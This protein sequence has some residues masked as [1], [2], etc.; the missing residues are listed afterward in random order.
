MIKLTIELV[1]KTSWFSNVRSEVTKEEWDFLR[2]EAYKLAD[3]KCE[4][5]GGKGPKWPVEC[6]EVWSY[7]GEVLIQKLERLIALCPSCH[8][9]K[10]IGLAQLKGNFKRAI[11]HLMKINSW[12]YYKAVEYFDE[13]MMAWQGRSLFKW[14]LDIKWLITKLE[15][16]YCNESI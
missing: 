5:C 11:H 16:G 1:P 15:K 3:Y 10:H 8:E 6:H 7:D 12:D 14:D 13:A 9:V 4:I 2:K